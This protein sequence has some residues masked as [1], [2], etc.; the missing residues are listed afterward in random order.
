MCVGGRGGGWGGGKSGWGGGC[1]VLGVGSGVVWEEGQ[2]VA[3]KVW[4]TYSVIPE[5]IE[6]YLKATYYRPL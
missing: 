1:G 2:V 5:N 3:G 6:V 4:V